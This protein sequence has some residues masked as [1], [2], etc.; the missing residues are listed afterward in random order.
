MVSGFRGLTEEICKRIRTTEE[1][2]ENVLWITECEAA[3]TI[4][5]LIVA[6]CNTYTSNNQY[7]NN[8]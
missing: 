6:S 1:V 8:T 7:I 5:S 2:P 4:V 3:T